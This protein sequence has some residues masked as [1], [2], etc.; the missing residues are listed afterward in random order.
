MLSTKHTQN[1]ENTPFL[2]VDPS[3]P[4]LKFFQW[5][6]QSLSFVKIQNL[7][8]KRAAKD[9]YEAYLFA[10]TTRW[11]VKDKLCVEKVLGSVT[12]AGYSSLFAFVDKLLN[13]YDQQLSA[14]L[15][16][17]LGQHSEEIL[18]SICAHQW[19]WLLSMAKTMWI[20]E[21]DWCTTIIP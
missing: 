2:S 20:S 1:D 19:T 4:A 8:D 3:T 18:N 16:R 5:T 11:A 15:S 17:M 13:I 14:Q 21:E 10:K 7:W 12:A 6:A 9:T